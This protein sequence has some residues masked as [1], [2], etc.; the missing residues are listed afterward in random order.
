MPVCKC[1][2]FNSEP[3][4]LLPEFMCQKCSKGFH[5]F[6]EGL[7]NLN[8]GSLK[9]FEDL[10]RT[11]RVLRSTQ[12]KFVSGIQYLLDL[13]E[14]VRNI[15]PG[16]LYNETNVN[17]QKY[18]NK[19]AKMKI[20]IIKSSDNL[21]NEFIDAHTTKR[22]QYL[23]YSELETFYF[24]CKEEK[25]LRYDIAAKKMIIYNEDIEYLE[26]KYNVTYNLNFPRR[27]VRGE[28]Y[29]S[30]FI[31]EYEIEIGDY[32]V[33]Y[34]GIVFENSYSYHS[35]IILNYLSFIYCDFCFKNKNY[36]EQVS[37]RMYILSVCCSLMFNNMCIPMCLEMIHSKR[38]RLYRRVV[39]DKL[40]EIKT[41]WK[42]TPF[43]HKWLSFTRYH[44]KLG[45]LPKILRDAGVEEDHYRY[46]AWTFFTDTICG[47]YM[48]SNGWCAE[49]LQEAIDEGMIVENVLVEAA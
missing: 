1:K 13:M 25:Y 32:D 45:I 41:K 38:Y 6:T 28:M 2:H 36:F 9:G 39:A 22:K 35:C 48:A 31:D 17:Y 10:K 37:E 16:T 5:K 43:S 15:L 3:E 40:Y 30:E 18:I 46:R 8:S 20:P 21:L 27:D 23:T 29:M 19:F 33:D 14:M 26:D 34:E 4:Y 44:E 11:K 24:W 49:A 42:V 7:A 12:K 47:H